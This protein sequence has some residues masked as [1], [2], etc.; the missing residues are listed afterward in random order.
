MMI[1][2]TKYFTAIAIVSTSIAL[3]YLTLWYDLR[4]LND[5]LN[6]LNDNIE[7]LYKKLN[8]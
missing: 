6:E 5:E 3:I 7:K 8:I 1:D 2:K 4:Y